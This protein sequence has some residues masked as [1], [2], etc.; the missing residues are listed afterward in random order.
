[1]P[2]PTRAKPPIP[3][4]I[5]RERKRLGL[6]PRDLAERLSAAGLP[7]TEGTVRT[8]EAGRN[9]HPDNVEGLE[10]IFGTRAPGFMGEPGDDTPGS[11]ALATAIRELVEELRSTRQ[12]RAEQEQRLRALEAAVALLAQRDDGPDPA[13]VAPGSTTG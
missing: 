9:P 11:L 7:V 13:P 12:E 4:W 3:A 8:W 5:I 10:R 2:T 6:K 1:V